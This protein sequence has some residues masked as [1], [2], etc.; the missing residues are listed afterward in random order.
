[1]F[2]FGNKSWLPSLRAQWVLGAL[3]AILPL[4][5][6]MAYALNVMDHHNRAQRHLVVISAKVAEISASILDQAKD[7]ERVSRQY[8]VLLM[9]TSYNNLSN[10]ASQTKRTVPY[11]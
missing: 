6:A 5:G 2:L 8:Q 7:L 11:N 1:M 9:K 10:S 4:L 3:I